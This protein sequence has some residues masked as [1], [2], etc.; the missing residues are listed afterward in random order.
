MS[1]YQEFK[2]LRVKR[3]IKRLAPGVDFSQNNDKFLH[4]KDENYSLEE[5]VQESIEDLN[6]A[7]KLF[8][9]LGFSDE[10]HGVLAK[11][12]ELIDRCQE[13]AEAAA[14]ER[15][16]FDRVGLAPKNGWEKSPYDQFLP[17]NYKPKQ[18]AV[19]DL[20]P[21]VEEIV[22]DNILQLSASARLKE[23]KQRISDSIEKVKDLTRIQNKQAPVTVGGFG[24]SATGKMPDLQQIP[25]S[26]IS[27][28]D[29]TLNSNI[30]K[31]E[32]SSSQLVKEKA[33]ISE[34]V[35]SYYS[36]DVKVVTNVLQTSDI[37]NMAT[38]FDSEHQDDTNKATEAGA[39]SDVTTDIQT[40][41]EQ[42][43]LNEKT[44]ENDKIEEEETQEIEPIRMSRGFIRAGRVGGRGVILSALRSKYSECTDDNNAS[45]NNIQL[46]D[47]ANKLISDDD[48]DSSSEYVNLKSKNNKKIYL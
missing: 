15:D 1:L 18:N 20:R 39:L 34:E 46:Q 27:S 48:S 10:T 4:K 14:D 5:I 9:K 44:S 38:I 19:K 40:E 32:N 3:A 6:R 47:F 24:I 2:R 33:K 37:S 12:V 17:G 36:K 45:N 11:Q 16:L 43:V 41:T 23:L 21:I 29:T 13:I 30:N 22:V 31:F 42:M 25:G 28:K 8:K 26:E 7:E 35:Q